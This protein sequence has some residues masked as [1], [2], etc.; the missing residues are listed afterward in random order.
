MAPFKNIPLEQCK[1]ECDDRAGCKSMDYG[2]KTN[3]C[4]LNDVAEPIDTT[5]KCSSRNDL[6]IKVTECGKAGDPP[7]N[8]VRAQ[9]D[10]GA[11]TK[12]ES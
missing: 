9:Y 4:Y 3:D 6:Y 12:V 2:T 1:K 8:A 7:A 11:T 10:L 5:G